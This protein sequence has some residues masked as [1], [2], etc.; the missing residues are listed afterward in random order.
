MS[1]AK[2]ENIRKFILMLER[3]DQPESCKRTA[4]RLREEY[5]IWD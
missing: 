4:K 1:E 3:E 5:G 2:R